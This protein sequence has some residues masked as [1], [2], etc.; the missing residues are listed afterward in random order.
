MRF[1]RRAI[2]F[3]SRFLYSAPGEFKHCLFPYANHL[4]AQPV[5]HFFHSVFVLTAHPAL[6]LLLSHKS[7]AWTYSWDTIP[8][9]AE[10]PSQHHPDPLQP[11]ALWRCFAGVRGTSRMSTASVQAPHQE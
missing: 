4:K 6:S 9:P 5:T 8:L 2:L 11:S 7:L 1:L 3:V 10:A